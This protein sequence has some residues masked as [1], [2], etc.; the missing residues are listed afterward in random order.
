M[1]TLYEL[2]AYAGPTLAAIA[3]VPL[4]EGMQNLIGLLDRL[5]PW[6]KQIGAVV[7]AF[8]LTKAGELAQV[9]IPADIELFTGDDLEGLLAGGIAMAI[10]AGKRASN[11]DPFRGTPGAIIALLFLAGAGAPSPVAAQSDSV[12]V[13][14]IDRTDLN[15]IIEPAGPIRRFR[16]DSVQF[17][18]TA[19]DTV[20]G[21]T[22]AVEFR[23]SSTNSNVLTIDGETGL[24]TFNSRGNASVV[25][26]VVQ[27]VGMIAT[28][29]E[30][31]GSFS[32]VFTSSRAGHYEEIGHAP[33]E[34]TV[35]LNRWSKMCWYVYDTLG[36]IQ[37]AG[38]DGPVEYG[39]NVTVD[40]GEA[41]EYV[42]DGGPAL[43][44]TAHDPEV[45][46]VAPPIHECPPPEEV[47]FVTP[48]VPQGA[49][50]E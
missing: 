48:A 7:I 35:G 14:V 25:V 22:L 30:Q 49:S 37:L 12:E 3:T 40:D 28:V 33:P 29:M 9:A 46:M 1:D 50:I 31:D 4:Y 42:S 32:E 8:G 15:V 43:L 5:P 20:S 21:D 34:N 36:R 13:T 2:V 47:A 18:A 44:V 17:S 38:T 11:A 26:E 45:G 6:A 16:G 10:H 27:L 19:I 41:W 23:W 39:L 24:A